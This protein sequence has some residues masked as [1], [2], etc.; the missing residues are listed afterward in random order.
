VGEIFPGEGAMVEATAAVVQGVLGVG[1]E[2]SGEVVLFDSAPMLKTAKGKIAVFP[3]VITQEM[4]D[5]ARTSGVA[6]LLGAS[7]A[8][9]DL[10]YYVG[11]EIGAA[12]TGEEEV[13]F[14]LVVTEG[15]GK[16]SMSARTIE[17]LKL[18]SGKAGAIS[19]RTQIR[20]GAVRPELIVPVETAAGAEEETAFELA[21]GRKVRLL[22]PPYFGEVGEV[23]EVP[24]AAEEV[25][26]GA[27]VPVVRVKTGTQTVTVPRANVELLV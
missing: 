11:E 1:G 18:M 19:G 23:V 16:L 14:P 25:P 22:R 24:H 12:V 4:I 20:A 26:T 15:L 17:V 2:S 27:R 8:D 3:G 21:V 5:V 10:T 6:G 7:I 13:P 9:E